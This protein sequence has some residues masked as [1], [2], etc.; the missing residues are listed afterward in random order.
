MT[1]S[2]YQISNVI[3]TYMRN[4]KVKANT[5]DRGKPGQVPTKEDSVSI[6]EEAMKKMLYERIEEKMAERSKQNGQYP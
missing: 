2:D 5:V 3:K 1:I 6:S 4:L